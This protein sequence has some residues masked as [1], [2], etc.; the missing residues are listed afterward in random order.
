[1]VLV[2]CWQESESDT[3]IERFVDAALGALD[4]IDA[5]TDVRNYSQAISDSVR[6]DR[7][8]QVAQSV[9]SDTPSQNQHDTD[10]QLASL[11]L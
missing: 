3:C 5:H 6:T 10:E 4:G 9:R 7:T 11:S 8:D 2:P 1:M